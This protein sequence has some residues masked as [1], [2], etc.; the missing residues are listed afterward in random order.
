M[1]GGG[2]PSRR[3]A[4]VDSP[5]TSDRRLGPISPPVQYNARSRAQIPSTKSNSRRSNSDSLNP[6]RSPGLDPRTVPPRSARPRPGPSLLGPDLHSPAV[7]VRR[8]TPA[9]SGRDLGPIFRRSQNNARS[10]PTLIDQVRGPG[11]SLLGPSASSD[12][13]SPVRSASS[14]N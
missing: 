8:T 14:R 12:R 10:S 4:T 13:R 7:R 11:P 9:P 3:S 2:S 5:P 1:G 6:P